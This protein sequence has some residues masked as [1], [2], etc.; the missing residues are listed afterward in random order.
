MNQPTSNIVCFGEILWD[1][2]PTGKVAGGAPMNVAF[3][4]KQ[5]GIA[6]QM[7]SKIGKDDLGKDLIDFLSQRNVDTSLI[8]TD[9]TYST[10]RVKVT[11]NAMGS[12]SYEIIAPIAWDFIHS[13][14]A[15]KTAVKAADAFVFP[16][17]Q[18]Q[19]GYV[20]IEALAS[21]LP[22]ICSKKAG[23]SSIIE[24]GKNGYLVNPEGNFAKKIEDTFNSIFE[25]IN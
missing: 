19:F 14:T 6:T 25:C 15:N 1:L 4:A 16:T 5:L 22:V 17:L 12:P 20:V 23:V 10:G 24:N 13:N 8:Q 3:H 9:D 2:L 11:L 21:G 7:I 18:D